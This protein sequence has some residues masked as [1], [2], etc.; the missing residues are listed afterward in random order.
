MITVTFLGTE[1]REITN[2]V[3]QP[4]T[5]QKASLTVLQEIYY[6]AAMTVKPLS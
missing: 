3:Q 2:Q 4:W 6:L 1:I 5:L